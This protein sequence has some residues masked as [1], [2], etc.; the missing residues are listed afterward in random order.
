MSFDLQPV[1]KGDL[2]E[3]RPLQ[4]TDFDDLF[5]VAADPL[6]WEQ[7]PVQ[8]R[9][10]KA[11]FED[12]FRDSLA[13]GGALIAVDTKLNKVIGSSRFHGYDRDKSEI[14]IGW[15]FLARS[16]WG[17]VYNREM[18][19]LMLRHAFKFVD[20]IVFLVGLQNIR[21]QRAVEKI[22]AVCA[23]TRPD[24]GGHDSYVYQITKSSLLE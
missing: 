19:Q 9:Y 22:G 14:E 10:R 1:L 8:N 17:G 13:S 21:S 4:A 24:A 16:H 6:I 11:V 12:F 5:S 20:R 7:H 23:G 3:L 18:K 15:T 2:L